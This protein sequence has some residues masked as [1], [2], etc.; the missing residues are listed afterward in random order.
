P[1]SFLE[2]MGLVGLTGVIVNDSIVYVDFIKKARLKGLERMEATIEAGRNR[3]RPIFLTTVTTFFGLI[4][5]AYGI[6][7]NNPFLKPMAIAM[8]WGLAFG[9]VIT[10]FG[11]LYSTIFSPISGICFSVRKWKELNVI[12]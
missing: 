6:G 4:P 11:L 5:T 10:L 7:G 1:L 12:L 3:L 8:S 9:T 2:I